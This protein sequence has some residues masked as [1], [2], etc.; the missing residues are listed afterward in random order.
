MEKG[1]FLI[2]FFVYYATE[3]DSQLCFHYYYVVLM[4]V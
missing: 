4:Q 3:I 2:I 1:K